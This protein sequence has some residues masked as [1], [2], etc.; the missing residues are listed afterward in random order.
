M[1]DTTQLVLRFQAGDRT[2]FGTLYA[3]TREMAFRTALRIVRCE[4]DADDMV[5][6]AYLR[7]W[8]ARDRLQQPER[9]QAWLARIVVNLSRTRCRRRGRFVEADAAPV[10]AVEPRAHVTLE[11]AQSRR[12]L[13]TAIATLSPRQNN[14]VALRLR[15]DLSFKE[16]GARLGCTDVAARVNYLYGVRNLQVRM[17]A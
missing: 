5:Q 4:S 7:A 14:V 1:T 13:D 2:S 11:R 17:A 6:A 12:A 9:F 3:L 16:I 10:P 15:E 8:E